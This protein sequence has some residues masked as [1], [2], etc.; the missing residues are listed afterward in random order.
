M[1]LRHGMSWFGTVINQLR[2]HKRTCLLSQFKGLI[3]VHFFFSISAEFLWRGAGQFGSVS[4][5]PSKDLQ[6]ESRAAVQVFEGGCFRLS[7]LFNYNFS[8]FASL[9]QVPMAEN[10]WPKCWRP[11]YSTDTSWGEVAAATVVPVGIYNVARKE[12][13]N[14]MLHFWKDE[15]VWWR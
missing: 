10:G 4:Q 7:P 5:I 1:N 3:S 8:V 13:Q 15:H 6:L 12:I 2:W 11:K 14:R 9:S